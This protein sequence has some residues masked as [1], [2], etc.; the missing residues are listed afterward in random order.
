MRRHDSRTADEG[1]VDLV[2]HTEGSGGAVWSDR[3]RNRVW[4]NIRDIGA[5]T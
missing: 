3:R 2:C 5:E 4:D 1:V